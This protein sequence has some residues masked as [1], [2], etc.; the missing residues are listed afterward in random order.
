MQRYSLARKGD[1][2]PMPERGAGVFFSA[3]VEGEAV[4][5]INPYYARLIADGD[6]KPVIDETPPPAGAKG[7]K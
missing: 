7:D 6:I 3:E 2:I 4:D 1:R 5:P